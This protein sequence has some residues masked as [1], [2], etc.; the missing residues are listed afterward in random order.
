MTTTP[1]AR[2]RALDPA[3]DV[4]LDHD[5]EIVAAARL[6]QIL[7]TDPTDATD[8]TEHNTAP[9]ARSWRWRI[10]LPLAAVATA[11]GVIL[12]ILPV[13][14]DPRAFA[15][16]TAV[17]QPLSGDDLA[18]AGSAC[19][20]QA[21]APTSDI[22]AVSE[23]RGDWVLLF[24]TG[25]VER[26]CLI[27]LPSGASSPSRTISGSTNGDSG[28]TPLATEYTLGGISQFTGTPTDPVPP[29]VF[30]SG[31][32][33]SDVA[34]L[35]IVTENGERIAA[36]VTGNRWVVWWPGTGLS[37]PGTSSG[38][39][40]PEPTFTVDLTLADGSI[41]ANAPQSYNE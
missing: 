21:P 39:G 8:P 31:E 29:A 13:G 41:I 17:A 22:P 19:R 35:T 14:P 10:V 38:R 3:R 24:Y 33:G 1:S 2:L 27:E 20:A 30:T 34:A 5:S 12:A 25:T 18:L 32:V 7:A 6:Q 11:A 37:D 4:T 40:G 15:S 28:F 26:S 23:R 9:A 36:T 16:W